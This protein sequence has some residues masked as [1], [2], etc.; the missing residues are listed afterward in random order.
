MKSLFSQFG[1]I[2]G[3]SGKDRIT[4]VALALSSISLYLQV[5]LLGAVVALCLAIGCLIGIFAGPAAGT[6][7]AIGI[8]GSI[9]VMFEGIRPGP[10]PVTYT[11]W[12]GALAVVLTGLVGVIMALSNLS[13]TATG[14]QERKRLNLAIVLGLVALAIA[15]AVQVAVQSI[16][17]TYTNG[18]SF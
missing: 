9:L 7:A 15:V 10:L 12:L 11:G 8:G 16:Y 6:G 3:T 5:I 13:S 4:L 17:G 14:S 18:G 1:Q 2:K